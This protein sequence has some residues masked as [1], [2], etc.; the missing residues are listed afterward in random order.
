MNTLKV[1]TVLSATDESFLQELGP[2][3]DGVLSVNSYS[4]ALN[5]PENAAFIALAKKHTNREGMRW[6]TGFYR[7][8]GITRKGS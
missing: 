6:K 8:T 7:I 1:L 3:G 4:V 2:V 5:T